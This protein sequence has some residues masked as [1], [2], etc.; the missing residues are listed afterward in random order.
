[1]F[2]PWVSINGAKVS[3]ARFLCCSKKRHGHGE[4][5][6]KIGHWSYVLLIRVPLVFAEET[7]LEDNLVNIFLT[8]DD[9]NDV[10]VE[11]S[12]SIDERNDLYGGGQIWSSFLAQ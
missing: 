8:Q 3:S 11:V 4:F 2:V 9:R 1:V 7:G 10:D 5:S 12:T 6:C